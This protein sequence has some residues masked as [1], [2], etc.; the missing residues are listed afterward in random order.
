MAKPRLEGFWTFDGTR[1]NI[2]DR[3][4]IDSMFEVFDGTPD[5]IDKLSTQDMLSYTFRKARISF[6]DLFALIQKV[7]DKYCNVKFA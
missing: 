3:S 5:S 2:A 7:V 4:V 6:D 1:L